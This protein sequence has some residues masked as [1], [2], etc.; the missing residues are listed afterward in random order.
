MVQRKERTLLIEVQSLDETIAPPS[1]P[2][3]AEIRD[4][5]RRATNAVE[6][7]PPAVHSKFYSR[8]ARLCAVRTVLKSSGSVRTAIKSIKYVQQWPVRLVIVRAF[9]NERLARREFARRLDL[10]LQSAEGA[11]PQKRLRELL[12]TLSDLQRA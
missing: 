3:H 6:S 12:G 10:A 2:L 9:G 1:A 7:E 11:E 5:V 4:A 8:D